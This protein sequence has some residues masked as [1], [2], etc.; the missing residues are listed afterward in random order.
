M[1]PKGWFGVY[2]VEETNEASAGRLGHVG[3]A[4]G[5]GHQSGIGPGGPGQPEEE[6]GCRLHDW[7]QSTNSSIWVYTKTRPTG[8][9]KLIGDKSLKS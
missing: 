7:L 3:P 6:E 1:V 2:L 8:T 5:K 4:V 9:I